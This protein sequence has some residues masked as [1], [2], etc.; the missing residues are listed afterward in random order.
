MRAAIKF[1]VQ[2]R[3]F[4]YLP[5][6]WEV[7]TQLLGQFRDLCSCSAALRDQICKHGLRMPS[8]SQERSSWL[9]CQ[10]DTRSSASKRTGKHGLLG[11]GYDGLRAAC[12]G[13]AVGSFP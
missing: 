11:H 6:L 12:C 10:R 3:S 5:T 1:R 7:E 8:P 13:V 9:I 2:V 4:I